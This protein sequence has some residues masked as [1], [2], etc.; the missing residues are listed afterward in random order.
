MPVIYKIS[1]PTGKVY[2]GQTWNLK[3]RIYKYQTC[4]T[5]YQPHLHNSLIKYGWEKHKIKVLCELPEDINQSILDTYEKT[6]MDFYQ[7]VGVELMNTRGGGSNGKLSIESKQKISKSLKE[8]YKNIENRNRV[9]K[10][11]KEYFS[12]EENRKKHSGFFTNRRISEET[13]R[14]ISDAHK[15]LGSKKWL[16]EANFKNPPR[17]SK[18]KCMINGVIFDC[19]K[20]ASSQLNIS[21][22]TLL[23][24]IKNSRQKWKNYQYE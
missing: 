24:R 19:V 5:N 9:S 17:R 3:S 10:K 2:I 16:Q 21:Y 23:F 1:S 7:G 15:K 8:Y 14:K 20:E 22:Y 11:L 6:Y 12:L 4:H 18:K 13:K